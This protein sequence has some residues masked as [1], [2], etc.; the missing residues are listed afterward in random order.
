[1]PYLGPLLSSLKE[2]F[3]QRAQRLHALRYEGS[4]SCHAPST[5]LPAFS[6]RDRPPRPRVAV[7]KAIRP[8]RSHAPAPPT[9][10]RRLAGADDAC[11]HHGEDEDAPLHAPAFADGWRGG[12]PPHVRRRVRDGLKTRPCGEPAQPPPRP[13]PARTPPPI[14]IVRMHLGAL[15]ELDAEASGRFRVGLLPIR[16]YIHVLMLMHMLFFTLL[17]HATH[18]LLIPQRACA[19]ACHR[20]KPHTLASSSAAY[21]S[22]R[23]RRSCRRRSTGSRSS[24]VSSTGA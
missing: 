15:T 11:G 22:R 17:I 24:A 16:T 2:P 1:M 3:A 18:T 6:F 14:E 23:P 19:H 12:S 9:P 5:L 10:P 4:H 7:D 13:P 20:E 8:G 21:R